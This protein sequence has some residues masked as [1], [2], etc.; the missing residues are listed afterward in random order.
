MAHWL[1]EYSDEED[2]DNND[3]LFDEEIQMELPAA[4]SPKSYCEVVRSPSPKSPPFTAASP[5]AAAAGGSVPMSRQAPMQVPPP[6]LPLAQPS[7]RR[8]TQYSRRR[9]PQA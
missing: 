3:N 9:R 5:L 6:P 4:A 7:Q 2:D 1:E 8:P